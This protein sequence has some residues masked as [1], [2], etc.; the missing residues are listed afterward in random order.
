MHVRVKAFGPLRA[1]TATDGEQIELPTGATLA[2]LLHW[3][4]EHWTERLPPSAWN[5]REHRFR[6]P[7]VVRVGARVVR[8]RTTVLADGEEVGI[9]Q[10]LVGG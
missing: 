7:V 3:I 9:H 2:D 1:L 6:G 5:R 10:A 8:D 4:G